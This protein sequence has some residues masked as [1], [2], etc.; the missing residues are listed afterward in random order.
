MLFMNIY[1]KP[2]DS[3]KGNFF[4]DYFYFEGVSSA[5]GGRRFEA[6]QAQNNTITLQEA[7][8]TPM[9]VDTAVRTVF[10]TLVKVISFAT[11]IFPL[12]MLAKRNSYR[13]NNTFV[14][15][16][17]GPSTAPNSS[18]PNPLLGRVTVGSYNILFPQSV[19]PSPF[20]TKIGYSVDQNG[21]LYSNTDFR[22][23]IISKNILNSNLDVVCLQ[24]MTQ[25]M[26]QKLQPTLGQ[27]YQ[28]VWQP[29]TPNS[30]GVGI[31]YKKNKFQLLNQKAPLTVLQVPN[32]NNPTRMISKKRSEVILDLRDVTT[33]KIYRI[34]SCHL[35]DPRDFSITQKGA[36]AQQ[37]INSTDAASPY[38]IDNVIIAG[39]MNQDQF[40]DVGTALPSSPSPHLATAFQPF[41][42]NGF[43]ADA[44]LDASEYDK[45]GF[46]NGP[47]VTKNR[48]IDWIFAKKSQPMYLP[49]AQFDNRGSDHRLVAA[50]V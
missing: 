24:E 17:N 4:E 16:A 21:R 49:L 23:Q 22:I 37:V 42:Q 5:L 36:H 32:A 29:H 25:D 28:V 9:T 13:Q 26:L 27:K 38:P 20:S 41:F 50:A 19:P 39:D 35:L 1:L 2:T 46:N 43:S 15:Q 40:G 3:V 11:I 44:N 8:K 47:I 10:E 18:T 12:L 14:L 45:A 31:L 6:I 48:R 30:H 33:Q 34:A 7:A